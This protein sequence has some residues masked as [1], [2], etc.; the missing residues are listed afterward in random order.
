[1]ISTCSIEFLVILNNPSTTNILAV[2]QIIR[3][4]R[5]VFSITQSKPFLNVTPHL[6]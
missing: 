6:A 4:S 5:V 1:M 2:N 3:Y